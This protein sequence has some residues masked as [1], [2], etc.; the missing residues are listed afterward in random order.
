MRASGKRLPTKSLIEK[1]CL[2]HF[3]RWRCS[4]LFD[5]ED[6]GSDGE[7]DK[8][9]AQESRLFRMENAK[10]AASAE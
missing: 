6:S 7:G 5:A 10:R 3:I 1:V 2:D 8:V 4:E 9:L